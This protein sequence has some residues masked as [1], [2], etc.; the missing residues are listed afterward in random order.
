MLKNLTENEK[1]ALASLLYL[2]THDEAVNAAI[3]AGYV[4]ARAG[5]P[6]MLGSQDFT[7]ALDNLYVKSC[8]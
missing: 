7:S 1:E 3:R 2:A 4:T 5:N 8:K 6:D